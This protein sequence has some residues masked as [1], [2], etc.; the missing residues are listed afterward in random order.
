[1]VVGCQTHFQIFY[2]RLRSLLKKARHPPRDARARTIPRSGHESDCGGV[3]AQ[4]NSRCLHG[5]ITG[6]S[7]RGAID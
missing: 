6:I 5:G 1:M 3:A 7:I 4:G 2:L